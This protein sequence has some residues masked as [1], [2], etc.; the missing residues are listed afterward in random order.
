MNLSL[1]HIAVSFT[2]PS[3]P[4][5]RVCSSISWKQIHTK[6]VLASSVWVMKEAR[7]ERNTSCGSRTAERNTCCLTEVPGKVDSFPSMKS[8]INWITSWIPTSNNYYYM[9]LKTTNHSSSHLIPPKYTYYYYHWVGQGCLPKRTIPRDRWAAS[10]PIICCVCSD[11][12]ILELSWF[13]MNWKE[14]ESS[15]ILGLSGPDSLE[16]SRCRTEPE[17]RQIEP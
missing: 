7:N 15:Y 5:A 4:R 12:A 16:K 3:R 2:E 13:S 9:N 1:P 11:G 6:L 14:T 10:R 8:L 17:M